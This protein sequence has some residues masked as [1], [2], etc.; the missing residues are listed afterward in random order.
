M[1]PE[2]VAI[3]AESL[4]RLTR[5]YK[6]AY[7]NITKE[8]LTATSFGV[9]NRKI[10]LRQIKAILSDLGE[11]VGGVIN[12]D[13]TSAYKQ[14][15]DEAIAQLNNIGAKINVETGFNLIHKQAIAALVD[16]AS[17]SFGESMTGVLRSAQ[18]L[19]GKTTREMIT[20]KIAEGMIGGKARKEVIKTIKGT[21]QNQG[22]DALTDKAGRTWEL[23]RYADM[24][25]RTKVVES[26]NRGLVNRMVENDYDLVQVSS[27][28]GACDNCSYWEGKILSIN[29]ST[30]GYP[31]LAEAE[32]GGLFHPNCRHAIN[33]LIPSL[34]NKTQAYNPDEPTKVI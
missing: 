12:T 5:L 32:S 24:L 33:V 27:H 10:I 9:N 20:Q 34:A 22:L 16:D 8:I 26:R 29:G 28:G 21:L 11:Q 3:N 17:L 13:L 6:R 23:D 19:L 15:A 25:Y 31:T 4:K 2:Q 1:Y 14:G 7:S 30:A 18:V